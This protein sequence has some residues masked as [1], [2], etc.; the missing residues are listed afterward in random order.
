MKYFRRSYWRVFSNRREPGAIRRRTKRATRCDNYNG[1]RQGLCLVFHA[2]MCYQDVRRL[3]RSVFYGFWFA[4]RLYNRNKSSVEFY[5][6]CGGV[7]AWC[8]CLVQMNDEIGYP[9]TYYE[10][11]RVGPTVWIDR[12]VL[13]ECVWGGTDVFF[14]DTVCRLCVNRKWVEGIVG[15]F[16]EIVA[17]V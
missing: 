1:N 9:H 15:I 14:R 7:Q 6:L 3:S 2:A 4:F 13:L 10:P 12:F 17:F 11:P 5:E 16:Q 8:I